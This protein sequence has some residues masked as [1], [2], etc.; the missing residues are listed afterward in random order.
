MAEPGTGC[1][2]DEPTPAAGRRLTVLSAVVAIGLLQVASCASASRIDL[3]RVE[4]QLRT[5]LELAT[6]EHIY[7][8]LVYY[9]EERS[10]LFIRTVDRAVLFS[11]DI[12]VRAGL[13]LAEG[14]A[15]T[16]DRSDPGRIYVRLPPARVLSVDADEQSIE[17]YF[18][19]EQGARIGLFELTGQLEAVKERT[20]ADAV[21]RGILAEATRN[22]RQVVTSFL[23]LAGFT[24]VTFAEGADGDA[25]QEIRG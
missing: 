25:E 4:D 9:G 20:A 13:D 8:D 7:R 12:R 22:A 11:I 5:I 16:R 17:Q 24:E 19:R 6:Y 10:F 2:T 21:R 1:R 3:I 14:V 15:L 23:E 18:I